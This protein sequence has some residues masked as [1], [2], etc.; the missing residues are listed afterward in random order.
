MGT[1]ERRMGSQFKN[2]GQ[3]AK[4]NAIILA[5][6]AKI[7]RNISKLNAV[8]SKF[9]IKVYDYLVA[10]DK[11]RVEAITLEFKPEIH[12]LQRVIIECKQKISDLEAQI[13]ALGNED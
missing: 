9:G 1:I 2:A 6:K 13:E 4:L 12:A 3:K 7:K 8:K 5:E 10:D 11:I